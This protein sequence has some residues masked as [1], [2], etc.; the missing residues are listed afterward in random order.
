[1]NRGLSFRHGSRRRMSRVDNQTLSPGWYGGVDRRWA[2]A[3]VLSL[4]TAC[5]SC[6]VPDPLTLSEP[7]VHGWNFRWLPVPGE[8]GGL[9]SEYAL[10]GGETSGVLTEWILCVLGPEKETVPAVLVLVAE[11]PKVP[12]NVLDL[13][14]CL[15]VGLWMIPRC[16]TYGDP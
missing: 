4:R 10:E 11:T 15:A 9:V 3:W 13:P 6:W 7:E 5:W 16:E 8:Q 14:L 12:P 2:S 1:M